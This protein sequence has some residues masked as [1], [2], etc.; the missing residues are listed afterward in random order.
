MKIITLTLSPAF[1]M[2]CFVSDFEPFHENLADITA[3]EAGGKGVNISRALCFA[4]TENLAFV[5]VG[6]ENGAEFLRAL[7]ADGIKYRSIAVSGRIRENITLH[8][9]NAPETRISFRGFRADTKL[10]ANVEAE[11]TALVDNDTVLTFTGR[12]PEGL[13]MAEVKGFLNRMR[14]KGARIVLDSRSFSR[15]D[16]IEVSP[17]LIKP[18]EEEIFAYSGRE[19]SD[20]ENAAVAAEELRSTGIE[21]VMISLGGKGAVLSADSGIYSVNAPK[22]DVLSTIGAGD[23][24]IAGFISAKA[25]G[26][27]DG[28]A[29][30]VA[31]AFGSAACMSEG[32]R[33]PMKEDVD[34]LLD[35]IKVTKMK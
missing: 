5:V 16:M 17:W 32:T 8:T 20:A 35:S 2:H 14:E 25:N 3:L 15:N 21:N 19:I 23:S 27:C 28:E 29:L 33:P 18:N 4:G 1:D 7:D 26:A 9:D 13:D 34:A 12:V 30:R 10:L 31:V 6:S 11:L 24:S 22:I